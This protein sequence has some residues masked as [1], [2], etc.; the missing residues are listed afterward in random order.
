[1]PARPSQLVAAAHGV[2]DSKLKK[3]GEKN[4]KETVIFNGSDYF[5]KEACDEAAEFLKETNAAENPDYDDCYIFQSESMNIDFD[6]LKSNLSMNIE[7]EIIG[8]ATVRVWNGYRRGVKRFS[9]NL[10]DI[11]YI[12]SNSCI[13]D[14]SI[15]MENNVESM[16]YH[17][18]GYYDIIYRAVKPGVSE[19]SIHNAIMR[20]INNGDIKRFMEITNSL[21]PYVCEAL[22]IDHKKKKAV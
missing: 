19:N 3:F 2:I 12:P 16:A 20:W 18:D 21:V 22:G 9:E 6:E 17:H 14:F 8:L 13:E 15:S 11:L 4:M 10:S 1:M 7:R 5:T